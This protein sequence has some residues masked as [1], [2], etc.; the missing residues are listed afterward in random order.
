MSVVAS[1]VSR[2]ARIAPLIAR[3]KHTLPALPYEYN[4]LEPVISREI[5]ELHH[6][7]HHAAYVNNLNVA[8]GQLK[9][10]VGRGKIFLRLAVHCL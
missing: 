5:M 2:P 1:L 7:K 8:E 9:D 6:T 4:A 3:L 10:Y